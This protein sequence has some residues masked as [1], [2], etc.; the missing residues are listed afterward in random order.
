VLNWS[1]LIVWFMGLSLLIAL[2][3]SLSTDFSNSGEIVTSE[4]LQ[5]NAEKRI[6]VNMKDDKLNKG[7]FDFKE[8]GN[9]KI[10][11]Q[12]QN[13]TTYG[14]AQ[15]NLY[16]TADSLAY[17]EI[18]KTGR[19][20]TKS[21]ASFNAKNISYYYVIQDSCIN[22]DSFFKIND[23]VKIRNQSLS[24]NFYLPNSFSIKF[25]EQSLKLLNKSIIPDSKRLPRMV[26]AVFLMQNKELQ[27]V[28]E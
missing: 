27:L 11:K 10:L 18:V 5:T 2:A 26:Q 21:E 16:H 28:S 23:D 7:D 8:I 20:S 24:L 4:N 13:L 17:L 3:I 14:N 25:D 1:I 15:I 12:N 22:I 6:F 19:G 9:Y